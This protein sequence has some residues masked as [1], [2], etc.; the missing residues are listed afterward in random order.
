MQ[1]FKMQLSLI[2][3]VIYLD[4][5]LG[6]CERDYEC[7]PGNKYC[8]FEYGNCQNFSGNY[9]SFFVLLIYL[10]TILSII[11]KNK[12]NSYSF[13]ISGYD[14][15]PN[16]FFSGQYLGSF[17]NLNAAITYCNS[18]FNCD[19]VSGK[20][21]SFGYDANYIANYGGLRT[22]DNWDSWVIKW[23]S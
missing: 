9:S 22:T 1:H 16:T 4:I 6:K 7:G 18:N 12:F 10:G 5:I 17:D 15:R 23:N 8:N 19:G 20:P 13:Q 14:Y 11:W 21:S 2:Y 3:G